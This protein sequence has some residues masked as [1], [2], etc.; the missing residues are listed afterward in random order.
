[1]CPACLLLRKVHPFLIPS[2]LVESQP[3]CAHVLLPRVNSNNNGGSARRAE[4]RRTVLPAMHDMYGLVAH[5]QVEPSNTFSPPDIGMRRSIFCKCL[6][7]HASP[8]QARTETCAHRHVHIVSMQPCITDKR[9]AA[10]RI[11]CLQHSVERT[12]AD[13][14][15]VLRVL[16][17]CPQTCVNVVMR[18]T[19][20]CVHAL[21]QDVAGNRSTESQAYSSSLSRND[22]CEW[23]NRLRYR[24]RPPSN[25]SPSS[26]PDISLSIILRIARVS[27]A[28]VAPAQQVVAVLQTVTGSRDL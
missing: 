8:I 26:S 15:R 4:I 16:R 10:V 24:C 21:I 1:M 7:D 9:K 2:N 20:Q 19:S 12:F 11:V 23:R 17:I 22:S 28:A 6:C 14:E 18:T 27:F 3:C 5:V 25:A 13:T